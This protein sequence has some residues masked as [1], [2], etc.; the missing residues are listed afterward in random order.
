MKMG[1]NDPL[2]GNMLDWEPPDQFPILFPLSAGETTALTIIL[3]SINRKN[4]SQ[5]NRGAPYGHQKYFLSYR[6]YEN[7]FSTPNEKALNERDLLP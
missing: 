7:I 4:Q 2:D 6:E 1:L 3:Q 5:I